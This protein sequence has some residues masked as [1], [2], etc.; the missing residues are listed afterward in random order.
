MTRKDTL[1]PSRFLTFMTSVSPTFNSLILR[2]IPANNEDLLRTGC[3][4]N[5]SELCRKGLIIKPNR[6]D[7]RVVECAGLLNLGP[8][9]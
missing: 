1:S 6:R 5:Q 7:G 9:L 2:F 8:K 4:D 3:Q